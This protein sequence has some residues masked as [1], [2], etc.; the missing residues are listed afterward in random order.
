MP[1][2]DVTRA[3]GALVTSPARTLVDM[4]GRLTPVVLERTLDEGLIGRRWR[5]SELVACL[6]RSS[7]Y[8][9]GRADLSRLLELRREA[10]SAD[11]ALEARVFAALS[12]LAPF[13]THYVTDVGGAVY[14]LDVAWPGRRVGAEIVGRA[15]RVVSRSAF[16]RERRKLNV[17]GAAGW[18]I[19]HLTAAMSVAEMIASVDAMLMR[20][21][22]PS[23]NYP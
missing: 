8:A 6:G 19:A 5:V 23:S 3:H 12:P 21:Q 22:S 2:Q 1:P 14:V 13:R 20:S 7:P 16:D 4:A 11:S 18:K 10:P 15:H 9:P 17:L